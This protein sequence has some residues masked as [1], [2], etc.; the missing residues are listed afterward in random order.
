M[1]R[2]IHRPLYFFRAW[3]RKMLQKSSSRV[4]PLQVLGIPAISEDGFLVNRYFA[5]IQK[6]YRTAN[7]AVSIRYRLALRNAPIPLAGL[8]VSSS[9]SSSFIR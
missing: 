8:V 6:A 5:P 7:A 2:A 3:D 9:A 4:Q 1:L